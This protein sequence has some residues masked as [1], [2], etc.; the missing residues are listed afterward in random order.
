MKKQYNELRK[1]YTLPT[2]KELNNNFEL[3]YIE[4]EYFL[5]RTIRRRIH[6]KIVFFARLFERIIFPNQAIMIEIYESKF[7]SEKE[8]KDLINSYEELL[9]LDRKALSLNIS[10]EDKKEAE[11][12]KLVSKK[13]PNLIKKSQF[14]L[15]K[16]D[17]SWKDK[18]T[19]LTKNHY[20]G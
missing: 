18:K 12:I 4:D 3:D 20:F 5:I 10:S 7:F 15:T 17:S 1:K 9:E 16:L 11:Y 2:Y 8:K 6:E 19:D 13:L 14:I